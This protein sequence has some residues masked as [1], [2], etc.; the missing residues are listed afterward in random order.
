M[1]Q[2]KLK[3]LL[4]VIFFNVEPPV[5][6]MREW[7]DKTGSFKVKAAYISVVDNK[8]QLHKETGV[9]IAVPLEK[10]SLSDFEYVRNKKGNESIVQST[11]VAQP[12]ANL[13]SRPL[14]TNNPEYSYNNFD[15]NEWLIKAGLSSSDAAKYAISFVEQK[16]DSKI[17]E[18]IDRE[19][20]RAMNISE[21][22][23]I[24]IR[25]AANLLSVSSTTRQ[26]I[27]RNEK[28]AEDKN[29]NFLKSVESSK[30][31]AAQ[32]AADEA[33]ARKLQNEDIP[34]R[35]ASKFIDPALLNNATGLLS[36]ASSATEARSFNALPITKALADVNSLGLGG[37]SPQQWPV[38]Q[39]EA[40]EAERAKLKA[41]QEE[42]QR[43]MAEAQA[44][45]RKTQEQ[46]RQ[47]QIIENQTRALKL[48]QAQTELNL[49]KAKEMARQAALQQKH[50]ETVMVNAERN[51]IAMQMPVLQPSIPLIPLP[52]NPPMV[53]LAHQALPTLVTQEGV[54]K[55]NW[56]SASK[57]V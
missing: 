52:S 14:N 31:T 55:P 19:A 15:W 10:L 8:V 23:I 20:L 42:T 48:Q 37:G 41:N 33:F 4:R 57:I 17:L 46:T 39:T 21:G 1:Y 7:T 49:V 27:E 43:L 11:I 45:L 30:L 51:A 40:L 47:A 12:V 6:Q 53:P 24:R 2:K 16:F 34:S 50:A 32:I 25:K 29:I 44:A 3:R 56:T 13:K 18:D 28:L 5:D 35:R 36:T 54:M 22:D 9:K 26:T 38:S